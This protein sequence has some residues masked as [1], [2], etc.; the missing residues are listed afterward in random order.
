M[1]M[2]SPQDDSA[3]L[4]AFI[5]FAMMGT[6]ALIWYGIP[7]VMHAYLSGAAGEDFPLGLT[8]PGIF[9]PIPKLSLLWTAGAALAG[10]IAAYVLKNPLRIGAAAA[11]VVA[12][13][14]VAQ[15]IAQHLGS[16]KREFSIARD[17]EGKEVALLYRD[18]STAAGKEIDPR[19]G[20]FKTNS[21]IMIY[22][23]PNRDL[24]GVIAVR[25]IQ[26]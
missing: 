21:G 5:A 13:I 4:G 2:R 6:V 25:R 11:V 22:P 14:V 26:H 3:R 10:G 23:N 1:T 18:A 17:P 16:K 20:R 9:S 15:P 19:T 24:T 12:G 7:M 8:I